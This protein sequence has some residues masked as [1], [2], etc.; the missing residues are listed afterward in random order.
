MTLVATNTTKAGAWV[1]TS[2]CYGPAESLSA[3]THEVRA[4]QGWTSLARRQYDRSGRML[5][6][7]VRFID[8]RSGREVKRP[9]DATAEDVDLLNPTVYFRFSDLPFAALYQPLKDSEK[10]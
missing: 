2:Y 5:S 10:Y 7:S 4:S 6:N 3:L 1:Q 8:S 9:R